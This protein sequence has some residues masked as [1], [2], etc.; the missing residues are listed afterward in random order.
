MIMLLGGPGYAFKCK[1][2]P[3]QT[4]KGGTDFKHLNIVLV[5]QH[6]NVQIIMHS[7]CIAIIS[8][9]PPIYSL[10]THAGL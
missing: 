3:C 7:M 6:L 5:R 10:S 4:A 1:I 2:E 9:G 8:L